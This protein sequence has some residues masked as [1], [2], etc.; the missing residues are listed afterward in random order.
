MKK[1]FKQNLEV[2]IWI[3]ALAAL[4]VIDP[5]TV[6][7]FSLCPL[8]NLGFEQCPGCGLG[9]SVSH[10]LH[11]NLSASFSMH[12]LGMPALFV[13]LHRI[14]TMLFIRRNNSQVHDAVHTT[15]EPPC[16]T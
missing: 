9:R 7:Q 15:Q 8:H 12:I 16:Q 5:V 3:V 10:A 14:V 11:G 13:L 6:Q 4:A 1:I 2:L